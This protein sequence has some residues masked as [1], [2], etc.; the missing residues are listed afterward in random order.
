LEKIKYVKKIFKTYEGTGEWR[1]LHNNEVYAL[2]SSPNN[3]QVIKSRRLRWSGHVG[4]MK[5]SRS[6]YR[7][8]VKNLREGDYLEYG[9][10]DGRTIL[11]WILEK[12]NGRGHRLDS[13]GSRYRQVAVSCECCNEPSGSIN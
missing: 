1:R 6:A 7:I 13:S 11:K 9:R 10:I 12:W 5:K 3:I 8:L 4:R 2:Y